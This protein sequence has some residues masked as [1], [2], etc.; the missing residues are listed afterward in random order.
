MVT[1]ETRST[2]A[3]TQAVRM[4]ELIRAHRE[5]VA[6]L[7][8]KFGD[9]EE[10]LSTFIRERFDL[11][12]LIPDDQSVNGDYLSAWEDDDCDDW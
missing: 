8:L 11:E 9:P 2:S 4:E 1:T 10:A 6:R 7:R 12:A 5:E 3:S